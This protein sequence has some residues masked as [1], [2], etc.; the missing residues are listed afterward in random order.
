[1]ANS[2]TCK[3]RHLLA[4]ANGLGPERL[5]GAH[6]LLAISLHEQHYNHN[7]ITSTT[8]TNPLPFAAHDGSKLPCAELLFQL[9]FPCIN[10]E[11]RG[12]CVSAHVRGRT[13]L[14]G[15]RTYS[16]EGACSKQAR[17]GRQPCGRSPHRSQGS[18]LT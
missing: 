9:D 4:L 17:E 12:A 18:F 13:T 6:D 16:R 7:T 11:R 8:S 14:H 1:M 3:Q 10:H 5:D 2:A 15:M